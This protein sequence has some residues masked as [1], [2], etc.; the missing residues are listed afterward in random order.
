MAEKVLPEVDVNVV[1][2][3]LTKE[4]EKLREDNKKMLAHI[5][6]LQKV[7]EAFNMSTST[8]NTIGNALET[9]KTYLNTIK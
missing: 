2:E 6:Q 9:Y 1:N 7:A 3:E 8:I 5:Q 4:N